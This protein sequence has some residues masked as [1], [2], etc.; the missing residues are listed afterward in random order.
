MGDQD[1]GDGW[2]SHE[3]H[4]EE[5]QTDEQLTSVADSAAND[6]A[7]AADTDGDAAAVAIETEKESNMEREFIA[8]S[9][10]GAE[11]DI[12]KEGEE[13]DEEE[14]DKDDRTD[15]ERER[16]RQKAL[17]WLRKAVGNPEA[18][19]HDGQWEAI[20]AVANRHQRVVVVQRTGWGKSSVYF[21]ATRLLREEQK[22]GPTLIISPLL[23]LMRNQ[24]DAAG[25]L[26]IRSAT[27]NSSNPKEWDTITADIIDNKVW[28]A[29]YDM[30]TIYCLRWKM[31]NLR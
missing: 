3:T 22:R 8:A 11:N 10:G 27:L 18:E 12:A 23:A 25:K 17:E 24:V 6:D 19:F 15:E 13:D 20:D 30:C 16:Q 1:M 9:D 28:C 7:A 26:G 14:E 2:Q 29:F 21:I 31:Q 4:A 5:K